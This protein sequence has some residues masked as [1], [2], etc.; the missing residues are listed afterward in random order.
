MAKQEDRSKK[1]KEI[2]REKTQEQRVKYQMALNHRP[3]KYLSAHVMAYSLAEYFYRQDQ[4]IT[5]GNS[6]AMDPETGKP[7]PRP[8][9]ITGIFLQL[10][11]DDPA[12][13][14]YRNGDMDH[15]VTNNLHY[16][17]DGT[18]YKVDNNK[19]K[20]TIRAYA[21]RV[22]LLPYYNILTGYCIDAEVL[23]K[24]IDQDCDTYEIV[25]NV[26]NCGITFSR[27]IQRALQI[28]QDTDEVR[29]RQKGRVGDI[30]T[31]KALHGW[32]DDSQKTVHQSLHLHGESATKLLSELGYRKI[33]D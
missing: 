18:P 19:D 13:Q 4:G 29:L 17:Q 30:M 16:D 5:W 31:V 20:D 2:Q 15:H 7:I 6:V 9:N 24:A 32:Q 28:I 3:P 8:Y 11:L 23:E 25:V 14:R 33:S 12:V 22:E 1:H 21:K 10:G 26:E 27:T